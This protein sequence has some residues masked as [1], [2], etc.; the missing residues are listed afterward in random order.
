MKPL[1]DPRNALLVLGLF[2][3]VLLGQDSSANRFTP[4]GN[5]GDP[6]ENWESRTGLWACPSYGNDPSKVLPLGIRTYATKESV[7]DGVALR[8][9]FAKGAMGSIT[10]ENAP[11]PAGSAGMTLYVKGS[12]EFE[13]SIRG[14][15]TFKVTKAW[16]KIDL[17]WE[18]LGTTRDKPDIG[19]QWDGRLTAPAPK[20]MW[21]IIDRVGCEGPNFIAK[22][23]IQPTD[24]PDQKINTREIVGNEQI[25]APTLQ[26]LKAKQPFKIIGFG[27]SVTAGAQA[28]RGNWGFKDEKLTQFL[29]FGHLARLLNQRYGYDGVTYVQ[30]GHGG[31]TADKALGVVQQDVVANAAPEDLVIIEFGANDMSWAGHSVDQWSSD[32]K[33]LIDAAKTKTSQIIITSPTQIGIEL[34]KAKQASERLR[35]FA[36]EQN[37]AYVDILHWSLYRGE[38]FSWAYEANSAHPSLMGHVMIGEIMETLLGAPH[39]DWP[40][41]PAPASH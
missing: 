22:P 11:F 7:T 19:Y 12:D 34:G 14:A 40:A 8:I 23:D 16:Q 39:F 26:R 21:V 20:D 37:V 30:K 29:Y 31:W 1:F 4:L 9:E 25:L 5:S 3:Q 33:K 41:G 6:S 18:K 35:K 13:M 28:A 24:G 2:S 32:L 36:A 10:Y 38:K 27:D 15:A 17:P